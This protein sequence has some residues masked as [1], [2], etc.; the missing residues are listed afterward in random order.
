MCACS[1]TAL[2]F[3]AVNKS[4]ISDICFGLLHVNS[5]ATL[6][7]VMRLLDNLLNVGVTWISLQ[8]TGI[9]LVSRRSHAM[10]GYFWID[11]EKFFQVV[12]RK[13]GR[14]RFLY[15][16]SPMH[17]IFVMC[18]FLPSEWRQLIISVMFLQVLSNFAV[19]RSKMARKLFL[20]ASLLAML[21]FANASR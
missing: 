5:I 6:K 13:L 17:V 1:D 18:H 20:V 3:H 8:N 14:N 16:P 11:F 15:V 7:G 4:I 9:Q 12:L 2:L 10:T 19:S 21:V